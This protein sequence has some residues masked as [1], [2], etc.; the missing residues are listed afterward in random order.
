M[1]FSTKLSCSLLLSGTIVL[2]LLTCIVY[3][4]N[5]NTLIE[6]QLL[7][8]QS[9]ANEVS[10]DVDALLAEKVNTSLTFANTP[11]I[12]KALQASNMVYADMAEE[13]RKQ[14]ISSLN[15]KW[16]AI[17]DPADDFIL[18]YTDNSVSHLL[19]QQQKLLQG[20]YGEIFLTNKFG[21]LLASTAKLTTFAH[22]HKY[23]WRGAYSN[24]EGAIFFDDR[25]YDD[26]VG[27]YVLGLVVPVRDGKEIIGILKFNL[28][29]LGSIDRLTS[30]AE[31]KLLGVFK[32]ARSGGMVVFEKGAEPLSTR[33]P[34]SIQYKMQNGAD[35]SVILSDGAEKFLVGISEIQ[36]THGTN[37]YGF[38]GTFESKDHKKGNTGESWYILGYRQLSVIQAPIVDLIQTI[39]LTG[40]LLTI[41]LTLISYV[42]GKKLSQPLT[43][44]DKGTREIG[45]GDFGHR[46]DIVG[47]DELA[48]LARSFNMMSEK[49][50]KSTTSLAL[51]EESQ[52]Y[53]Q[54]IFLVAPTGI[55]VITDRVLQQVN[56]QMCKMTG[57]TEGELIGQN[58]RV[59]Y[60]DDAEFE[61]VGREKYQ[62]ISENGTGIVETRFR[63]K[64][65]RCIDALLS[66]TPIDQRDLSKGVTFTVLDITERKQM[67]KHLLASEKMTSIAGL[68]AGV[69]HEINTPLSAITQAHQL[70]EMAL[71]PED[72]SSKEKAA[73]CGVDLEAVRD[74]FKKNELDFFMNGIRESAIRAGDIIKKLLD[75]SHPHE[76]GF[77][78]VDLKE[79]IESSILLSLAD[80]GMKKEFKIADVQINKEYALDIRPLVC[81]A[82]EIEQVIL[83]LIKN[84][85]LSMAAADMTEKPCITLRISTT[86]QK[87]VI[88]VEDNGP[89]I[90]K[91]IQNNIFDPFFTTKEVGK[92]IGL[93]LSVTHAIVVDKHNGTIRVE[94][95][96]GQGATFIVEIPLTREM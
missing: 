8:S 7:Y 63:R 85:A 65:G 55:G 76:G 12:L 72:E 15:A 33:V 48:D 17:T 27:G 50:Q 54:S 16:K 75:F 74:Y 19:K 86:A 93:G 37:G 68:A 24:G 6:S 34:E 5:Y 77:S 57:Y 56:P 88:E 29:V 79:I 70:V 1:K 26:S 80:Y 89:G 58:A 38:G 14:T 13:E 31:D 62:Q 81:V 61:R 9:I 87:A 91:D 39:L 45:K 82:T 32:L 83:N 90:T 69:A 43:I 94:S 3:R 10:E 92:G 95:E 2:I 67:E 22:G 53:L 30:T 28:N 66:S 49:L 52:A 73:E 4:V 11:D 47:D 46:I 42:I 84:S 40:L 35:S 96:P 41:L 18:E 21:T 23:W 59:L 25:G 36:L 44:I 51:L 20:E 64:D 60:P 78:T 71:S